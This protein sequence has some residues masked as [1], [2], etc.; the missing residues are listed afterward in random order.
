HPSR[1]DRSRLHDWLASLSVALGGYIAFLGKPT[2]ALLGALAIGA[3]LVFT[4]LRRSPRLALQRALIAGLPCVVLVY[5][6]ISLV[7]PLRT[8]LQTVRNG[9]RILP[10]NSLTALPSK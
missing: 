9:S 7:M 5:A 8:F 2:G 1:P 10:G 3:I 4:A 6:H